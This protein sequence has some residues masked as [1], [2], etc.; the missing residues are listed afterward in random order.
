MEMKSRIRHLGSTIAFILVVACSASAKPNGYGALSGVVL[1]PAGTPQMGA[2]VWLVSEDA[3]S[4]VIAQLLTN[5][6]G[7]FFNDHLKPGSY[8]VRVSLAGFLPALEHHVRVGA[9][10]TTLLR[11]QV[12]SIFASLDQLRKAPEGTS[13]PDDWKWALRSSPATRSVL[14]WRNGTVIMAGNSPEQYAPQPRGR[15]ELTS[16]SSHPGSP[17]NLPDSPATTMSYDQTIGSLGRMLFAGQMSYEGHAAGAFAGVWLPTGQFNG[18]ETQIVMRQAKVGF[19][20]LT[21]Q[22]MRID[23]SEQIALGDRITLHAGAE[24]IHYGIVSSVSALHPHGQLDV[25]LTPTWTIT[26]FMAASPSAVFSP[27]TEALQSAIDQLDSL[28][29]VMFRNGR[30]VL[31]GT[32]H[33]ELALRHKI[34]GRS[35]LDVA[36]FHEAA[37]HEAVFGSGPAG[38]PEFF[39]DS[40]SNTFLYDGGRAHSWGTRVAYRQSLSNGMNFTALY[41]WA[42]ALSPVG[43]LAPVQDNLRDSLTTRNRHSLSARVSGKV[44]RTGTQV[45]VSYKWIA[46]SALTRQD[47]FGETAY[48]IAPYMNVTVRQPLPSFGS[49]SKWEVLADFSNLL[50]EGYTSANAQDSRIILAPVQRS[51]R[52]GVSFQF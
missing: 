6:Q 29:T 19:D 17:S 25:S 40:F 33:E 10:L 7:S 45:G 35:T 8:S 38:S 21:F 9:N 14:Q 43:D 36:A 31:D 49:S 1:D 42:G 37:R 41:S 18:P 34:S 2:S 12:D 47:A 32:W 5:Q 13:E 24:F 26:T 23:H 22:G 52:G 28:P 3:S 50:A 51:F 27:P 48:Q 20:S 4:Q 44:P 30:P 39:Q 11:V 15:V 16:G 46:G